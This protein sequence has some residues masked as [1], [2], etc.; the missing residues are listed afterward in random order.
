MQLYLKHSRLFSIIFKTENTIKSAH[1][2]QIWHLPVLKNNNFKYKN[3]HIQY[4]WAKWV[5]E[6]FCSQNHSWFERKQ[7][8]CLPR[9]AC[10]KKKYIYI[11]I[12]TIWIKKKYE[13]FSQVMFY[14]NFFC[15]T[16]NYQ[17]RGY[18]SQ[19]GNKF[20]YALLSLTLFTP[21][22]VAEL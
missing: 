5:H 2:I 15:I 19:F 8:P 16:K 21:V 18:N 1:A 20:M 22:A 17:L 3:F 12:Y 6:L 14:Q 13:I 7:R 10:L 11:Y 9:T 4:D